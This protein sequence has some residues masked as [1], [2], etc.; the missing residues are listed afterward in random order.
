M[1]A[2][3]TPVDGSELLVV[4]QDGRNVLVNR[5]QAQVILALAGI[6]SRPGKSLLTERTGTERFEAIQGGNLVEMS[7]S[8]LTA[9]LSGIATP[10]AV[11]ANRAADFFTGRE[12]FLIHQGTAIAAAD[13]SQT[14]YIRGTGGSL[15]GYGNNF[16]DDGGGGSVIPLLAL[17]SPITG[18]PM[19]SPITGVYMLRAA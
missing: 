8:D 13:I 3:I 4:S 1:V 12:R 16:P 9:Y 10:G 19:F 14:L 11:P 7:L 15:Q 6:A 2:P 17:L 18:L 5:P